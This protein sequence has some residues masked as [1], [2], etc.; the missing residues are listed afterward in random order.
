MEIMEM[1]GNLLAE[2]GPK[3]VFLLFCFCSSSLSLW[4]DCY[5]K[6]NFTRHKRVNMGTLT[7]L[8][9]LNHV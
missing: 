1:M 6:M 4:L 3:Q 9:L 7:D 2:V 8:V 5:Q